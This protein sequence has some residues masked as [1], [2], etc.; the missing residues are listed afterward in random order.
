M[1]SKTDPLKPLASAEKAPYGHIESVPMGG[2]PPS[3]EDQWSTIDL[4]R[5]GVTHAHSALESFDAAGVP[6]F[7][8]VNLSTAGGDEPLA[9]VPEEHSG[10]DIDSS[11]PM[12]RFRSAVR[13]HPLA[14]I[15]TAGLL[16]ALLTRVVRASLAR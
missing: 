10:G 8:P 6:T 9:P 5:D 7:P 4:L 16:G 13:A 3:S 11:V 14:A 15:L 12:D 2:L 1:N